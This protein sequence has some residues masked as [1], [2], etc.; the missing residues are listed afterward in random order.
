MAQFA[1]T[2]IIISEGSDKITTRG[3][4]RHSFCAHTCD[5]PSL[6]QPQQRKSINASLVLPRTITCLAVHHWLQRHSWR[7]SAGVIRKP[8]NV[9]AMRPKSLSRPLHIPPNLNHAEKL[10]RMNGGQQA[11]LSLLQSFDVVELM[12]CKAYERSFG[13]GSLDKDIPLRY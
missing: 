1:R 5:V 3:D 4:M 9:V 11:L 13:Q 2:S 7:D 12:A 10:L 8:A 6:L